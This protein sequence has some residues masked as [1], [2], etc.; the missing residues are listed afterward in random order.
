[1][2]YDLTGD[3]HAKPDSALP[4]TLTLSQ[5]VAEMLEKPP[6]TPEPRSSKVAFWIAIAFLIVVTALLVLEAALNFNR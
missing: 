4:V 3:V 6:T 2:D 5:N 1:V